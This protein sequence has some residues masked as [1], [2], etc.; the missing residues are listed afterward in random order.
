MAL[1]SDGSGLA[2]S[3]T[4]V[5]PVLREYAELI[6]GLA[7]V[8]VGPVVLEAADPA[9][10]AASVR[11]LPADIRLLTHAE[12][13]RT[14]MVRRDLRNTGGLPVVT[15]QDATAIALAAALLAALAQ[16]GRRPRGSRVVVA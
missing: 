1:V 8:P 4:A 10:L 14:R 15:D 2:E 16:H 7:R 3:G 5:E 9:Q 12:P 13:G 6:S 11:A